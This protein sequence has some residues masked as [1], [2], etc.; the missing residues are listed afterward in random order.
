MELPYGQ[1]TATHFMTLEALA[2]RE[3]Q[4]IMGIG[5]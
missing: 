5:R 4:K 3:K 2:W 1:K